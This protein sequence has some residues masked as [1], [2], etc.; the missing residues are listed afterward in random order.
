LSWR[1]EVYEAYLARV[2]YGEGHIVDDFLAGQFE[3][4]NAPIYREKFTQLFSFAMLDP[5]ISELCIHP[6][7]GTYTRWQALNAL[8]AHV[9]TVIARNA[10]RILRDVNWQPNARFKIESRR[11]IRAYARGYGVTVTSPESHFSLRFDSTL[12]GAIP[13]TLFNPV[14]TRSVPR[15]P[16]R[17]HSE[18]SPVPQS[19]GTLQD[20]ALAR[21]ARELNHRAAAR[22]ALREAYASIPKHVRMRYRHKMRDIK[23]KR[24]T[25]RD[26]EDDDMAETLRFYAEQEIRMAEYSL[27]K[28]LKANNCHI[29]A[30][31]LAKVLA[32]M[33]AAS[34]GAPEPQSGIHNVLKAVAGCA[35]VGAG[36][37]A[38]HAFI[39]AC[40]GISET[41]SS[42]SS[43][44]KSLNHSF[45]GMV[46]SVKSQFTDTRTTYLW[47]LPIV[48]AAL[49]IMRSVT[50]LASFVLDFLV[51]SI[52]KMLGKLWGAV[53]EIFRQVRGAKAAEPEPQSGLSSFFAKAFSTVFLA[54]V[55]K[56]QMP[57]IDTLMRRLS[58]LTKSTEGLESFMDWVKDAAEVS[59]NWL[60]SFFTP[61]RV[62]WAN[63]AMEPFKEVCRRVER[64]EHDAA[65]ASE[66]DGVRRADELVDLMRCIAG[67][68][69]IYRGGPV[70]R[71][72]QELHVRTSVLLMP[73]AGAINARNNH[74]IQPVMCVLRGAPGVGKTAIA[75]PIAA[76][77]MLEGGLFGDKEVNPDEIAKHI[78]S[79]SISE[80]WNGYVG[81]KAIVIDDIFQ[82]V[83]DHTTQEN[84]YINVIRMIGSFALPL[85]MA[86]LASKGK[87]YFCSRLVFGTTN[88]ENISAFEKCVTDEQAVLRRMEHVYEIQ[89]EPEYALPDGKLDP[90]KYAA[91]LEAARDGVGYE[92]FPWQCW[93]ARTWKLGTNAGGT[94]Q[95]RGGERISMPDLI[96]RVGQSIRNNTVLHEAAL[97]GTNHFVKNFFA[98][99]KPEPQSGSTCSDIVPDTPRAGNIA[100]SE[101]EEP[102]SDEDIPPPPPVDPGP[103]PDLQKCKSTKEAY[104]RVKA[105][106]VEGNLSAEQLQDQLA[107][108]A[109]V[110][111]L[112]GKE[113]EKAICT[114]KTI[115]ERNQELEEDLRE[116]GI[117]LFAYSQQLAECEYVLKRLFQF[118]MILL[119]IRLAPYLVGLVTRMLRGMFGFGYTAETPSS[120]EFE[121]AKGIRERY[122]T[123]KGGWDPSLTPTNPDYWE[124]KANRD[125]IDARDR[126]RADPKYDDKWIWQSNRPVKANGARKYSATNLQVQSGTAPEHNA[127][128]KDSYKMLLMLK[129]D[130]QPVKVIGQV[131]AV[132]DC[133]FLQPW[134]FT[135]DVEQSWKEGVCDL[136]SKI[137]FRNSVNP[138]HEIT[139]SVEDYMGF[140]RHRDS[141][142]D[143]EFFKFGRSIRAARKKIH[144]FIKESDV[145]MLPGRMTRLD[146]IE[147]D[148]GGVL[149]DHNR[150]S[151]YFATIQATANVEYYGINHARGWTYPAQTVVGDCGGLLMLHD[152]SRMAGR[153]LCGIHT[154]YWKS[155][156]KG[157]S[158][159]VTQEMCLAA[160]AALSK[161]KETIVEDR[162]EE[163]LEVQC[164]RY[165]LSIM[166]EDYNVLSLKPRYEASAADTQNNGSF[167][168]L[169]A[170]SK[171]PTFAPRTKYRPTELHGVFGPSPVRPAELGPASRDGELIF[172]MVRAYEPY[173]TPVRHV[174]YVWLPNA[175]QDAMRPF[176][177]ATMHNPRFILS[178]EE[179]VCGIPEMNFRSLP[180]ST[181]PGFPWTL[182]YKNGKR[183]MFGF[184]D[185][186][187]FDTEGARE[188]RA[189]VDEI[190]AAAS[191]G[192]RLLNLCTDFPKDELRSHEKVDAV[193]TR[194]I[195]GTDVAYSIACRRYFGAF[196]IA[197]NSTHKK[198]GLC[199]GICVYSDWAD[200]RS[201]ITAKGDKVFDGDF[202]GF[203]ASQQPGVLMHFLD[204]MNRWYNDGNDLIRRV[205]FMDLVHSRHMGGT[206][207][208]QSYLIQWN[209]CMPSG[210][211]L[212]STINSMYS[213]TCLASAF[214][215]LTGKFGCFWDYCSAATLGDDNIV[216]VSD[217]IIPVFNQ[218]TVSK[219]L[220]EYFFMDYTAGRKGEALVPHLSI[221][222]ITFLRRRFTTAEG[223][224]A[225]PL[226]LS[227]FLYTCYYCK[228][229]LL[230]EHILMDNL[231]FALEEL[232]MHEPHVWD[233]Y[234][235]LIFTI[236]SAFGKVSRAEPT[237]SSYLYLV[238]SR[239]DNGW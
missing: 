98:T 82:T 213:M 56:K 216:G 25:E 59:V 32:R 208:D 81:Q 203:D 22:R 147:T 141:H 237:R 171:G 41:A 106:A 123:P 228:N 74:R 37:A 140:A 77:I 136:T 96:K 162:W 234:A 182:K 111:Y 103:P 197:L 105:W 24:A 107:K 52:Q 21:E 46:S 176:S 104:E 54:C 198:S 114:A 202:K 8:S 35:A 187:V 139:V 40:R 153:T 211:F 169:A 110:A 149:T 57:W 170:L 64:A 239:T 230:V 167:M 229:W 14:D 215:V 165:G 160:V 86:D 7:P 126:A 45:N 194:M 185:E 118:S 43:V 19:G 15:V 115:L 109:S 55:F 209:K 193:A 183:A 101:I 134:H 42:T 47:A 184:D 168:S 146:V 181:S 161:G 178:F 94:E 156:H 227:S 5:T 36:V 188:V 204:Y 79:K 214:G 219:F 58:W 102:G 205:L 112:C 192:A 180:R 233:T 207:R 76:A 100:P 99:S 17:R 26:E 65:V 158:P 122:P 155:S 124:A 70:E 138:G 9:D 93:Y 53:S 133:I 108:Y 128:Y 1:S 189:R 236:Q 39:R 196:V 117:E 179:A 135:K 84:D 163:D 62:S 130:D 60:L 88:V 199:P 191:E 224:V 120:P 144:F 13:P 6:A 152:N 159:V 173:M 172:P 200:L 66:E 30:E 2:P 16:S 31:V 72:I 63:K 151:I 164:G 48:M 125:W 87:E 49:F 29:S 113:A 143:I 85:N 166:P 27:E 222:D 38:T 186:Y 33:E 190:V 206:G 95:R 218:V 97:N 20:R 23:P 137:V 67:L 195:S 225:C 145:K 83:Q 231:E 12:D 44:L 80:Y 175:V 223:S 4:S 174:D 119:A 51:G 212:T 91:A 116:M 150:R 226:D 50:G 11:V 142:S 235:P 75:N 73:L 121:T 132:V 177:E 217:D 92:G 221:N 157:F 71:R 28:E 232:S 34:D 238:R 68:R 129:G 78:W 18:G 210:H 3:D 89:V 131:L 154:A 220:K 201:F 90:Q 148:E 61:Y 10:I 69:E 127:L